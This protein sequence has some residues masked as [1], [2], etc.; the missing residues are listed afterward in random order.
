MES[1]NTRNIGIIGTVARIAVGVGFVL[2]VFSPIDAVEAK[3]G[4]TS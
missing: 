2:A 1:S 4:Q 3:M